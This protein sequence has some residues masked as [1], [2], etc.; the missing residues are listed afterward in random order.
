MDT[1]RR[2][3]GRPR[4]AATT[5]WFSGPDPEHH[6][7]YIAFGYHRVTSRL[8]GDDWQLTWDEW[9]DAWLPYWANRGR[10]A[11]CLCMTRRDLEGAWTVNNIEIITRR[12][13]GQRIR[14]HYR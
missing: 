4:G 10:A 1:T 7:M 6:R 12:L 8:R 14:E 5:Q 13:H 9:R 3:V 11:T 2:P